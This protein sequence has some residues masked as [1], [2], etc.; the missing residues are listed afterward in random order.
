MN[1]QQVGD[2]V[3]KFYGPVDERVIQDTDCCIKKHSKFIQ[4]NCEPRIKVEVF[5]RKGNLLYKYVPIKVDNGKTLVAT[6]L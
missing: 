3:V 1:V 6:D 2:L 4:P 5:D